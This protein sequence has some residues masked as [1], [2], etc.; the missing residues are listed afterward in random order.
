MV[1]RVDG[2]S[3]GLSKLTIGRIWKRFDLEPH[4]QESFKL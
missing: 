4:I 2:H 1:A 3:P